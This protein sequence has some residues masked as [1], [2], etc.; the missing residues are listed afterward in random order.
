MFFGVA[1]NRIAF[2]GRQRS[3]ILRESNR[4]DEQREGTFRAGLVGCALEEMYIGQRK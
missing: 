1:A 2:L 4:E 3:N